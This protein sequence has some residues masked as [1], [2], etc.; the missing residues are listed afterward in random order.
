MKNINVGIIGFGFM[1]KAHT[2]GYKTIPLYYENLPF[3]INLTAVCNRTLSKAERAKDE[4]GFLYATDNPDDVINDKNIHVIN[5]CT[6]NVSHEEIILK[7]LGA[8]KH[9]Y[10]DKPLTVSLESAEKITA[11]L[12][13]K[14]VVTQMA[15]Q[16]RFYPAT[17]RAKELIEE[18]RLGNIISFRA[19]YLHS[20]SVDKNKP[21]GWKQ[22]K[23][24][25]GGGVLFDLGSHVLDLIY[26]LVGEYDEVF[27]KTSILYRERP[28]REGNMVEVQADDLALIVAKM[29]NGALGTV[30]ASKIATGTND[31]LKF[32][33][34]GDRGAIRFS[35]MEANYLDFFDNTVKESPLGGERGF[36]AI[37]CVQRYPK[38]GGVFPSS[39]GSIGWLRGHVH[40]LYNFL[41]SV[42][43]NEGATPSM[44]DGAYIQK[45]MER[46][47]QSDREKK[48]IKI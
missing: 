40:S 30:E 8:G 16:Y 33:I 42:Y 23:E 29:K 11:L 14:D 7:A 31:E 20:G 35:L 13:T 19:T 47:Y 26:H 3:K 38:P 41:D 1:G 43:A 2:Y 28:D 36:L 21:M 27:A 45:V 22:E 25:G 18:N 32:E 48:W 15:L 12:K 24:Q 34:H 4:L 9:I 17:M 10:C 6:P 46:A 5:I 39:K 37:E 44:E